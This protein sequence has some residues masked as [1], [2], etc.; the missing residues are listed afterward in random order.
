MIVNTT[1]PFKELNWAC[2]ICSCAYHQ[3]SRLKAKVSAARTSV[4]MEKRSNEYVT[5]SREQG[6]IAAGRAKH[7]AKAVGV[8]ERVNV[9]IVV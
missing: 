9:A 8:T 4:L 5:I 6:Q 2:S 1:F 7:P 3:V